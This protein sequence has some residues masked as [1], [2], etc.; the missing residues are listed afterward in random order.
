MH[1]I[2]SMKEYWRVML[3]PDGNNKAAECMRAGYIGVDTS[4]R[5]DISGYLLSGKSDFIERLAPV[6]MKNT[7][8]KRI[9]AGLALGSLWKV[10]KGMALGDIVLSPDGDKFYVGKISGEY[11]YAEG[12][13]FIHRRRVEWFDQPIPRADMPGTLRSGLGLGTVVNVSHYAEDIEQLLGNVGA[14]AAGSPTG[15]TPGESPVMFALEKHLEDF[16]VKNWKNTSLGRDYDIYHDDENG[17]AQQ[18]DTDTGP[19]DILAVSKDGKTLL[20]IELKKGDATDSAVGQV[21]RYMGYVKKEIAE[22]GQQV[23]GAI[24]AASNDRRI[25]R[26]LEAVDNVDFYRYQVEFKIEP[27]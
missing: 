22:E 20:V 16:L 11:Y 21:L 2:L 7:G 10:A 19:I 6:Y 24:V 5:E 15:N 13:E 25:K 17:L 14:S 12:Q 27:D 26:A 1:G 8:K 18:F 9:G 4:I 3:K 23:R